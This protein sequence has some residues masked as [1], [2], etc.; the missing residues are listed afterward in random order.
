MNH[1]ERITIAK[2]LTKKI[3]RKYGKDIYG[4]VIYGSVAKNEDR[5][6]SDLEMYVVTKKK[7]KVKEVK[8]V[9]RG[10]NI[11]VSYIP[12]R[13]MLRNAKTISLNWP[14]ATDFYR[15]YLILYE[16]GDWFQKLRRAVASQNPRDFKRAIQKYLV[17]FYELMAKI[18]NAYRYKDNYSFLWLAAFL[19]WESIIFLGLV[20]RKYYKSER[21]VFT[22]VMNFPIRPKNYQRLLETVCHFSV[23][24]KKKI[25]HATL[26]LFAELQWIARERGISVEENKLFV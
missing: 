7:L 1:K 19:G 18:K 24:D 10:M 23:K 3:V 2:A 9:Y 5:R 11:E 8:Y 13:E 17:W 15:S 6:Y 4:I 20:N 26:K 21:D 25:Y 14:I 22:S 16:K 12:A